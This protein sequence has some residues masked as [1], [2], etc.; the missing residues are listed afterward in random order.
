MLRPGGRLVYST[1]TFAPEENECIVAAALARHPDVSIA[2]CPLPGLDLAPG[3]A[4]WDGMAFPPEM[5]R[6]VR[7]W[8]GVTDA[9]GFFSVLLVK[10]GNGKKQT[11]ARVTDSRGE[12][13]PILQFLADSFGLPPDW[14]SG[15]QF[16]HRGRSI[17]L[18]PD[19]HRPELPF[20]VDERGF[21]LVRVNG[22][23]PKLSTQGALWLGH[24]VTRQFVNLTREDVWRYIR[25]HS[26]RVPASDELEFGYVQVRCVDI[27]I[28]VGLFRPDR[29]ELESLYPRQWG[30]M[31]RPKD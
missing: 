24:R 31:Q 28:G 19:D 15:W 16:S 27:P 14:T 20:P 6:A 9:G 7:L 2:E 17:D 5:S 8:P 18:L 23:V 12:V 13:E 22:R 3:L 21:S 10:A 4:S 29:A 26:V 25:G 1:C 11:A 30:G